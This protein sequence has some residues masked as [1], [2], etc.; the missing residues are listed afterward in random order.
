MKARTQSVTVTRSVS[1]SVK[2]SLYTMGVVTCSC[3]GKIS[4][5]FKKYMFKAQVQK[6]A[7]VPQLPQLFTD[8]CF[9]KKIV[10]LNIWYK[11]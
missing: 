5:H 9:T 10:T 7:T 4:L 6:S 3:S 2:K 8:T 11:K 1:R